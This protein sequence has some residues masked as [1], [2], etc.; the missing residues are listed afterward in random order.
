M[1]HQ[2]PYTDPWRAHRATPE[3]PV[4]QMEHA[5]K[6]D[7]KWHRGW[8]TAIGAVITRNGNI[9]YK[10]RCIGCGYTSGPLPTALARLWLNGSEV[11]WLKVNDPATYEECVVIDCAQP[12][13]DRHHFAPRNTFVDADKWPV[14]PLCREHHFYWHERMNGYRWHARRSA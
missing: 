2:Y 3:R 1:D 7:G 8:L 9:Q 4:C 11:A 6:R 5:G 12:G 14:L 13:V 10:G